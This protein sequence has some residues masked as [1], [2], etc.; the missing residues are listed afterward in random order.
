MVV[1]PVS[2]G[3]RLGTRLSGRE[4]GCILLCQYSV[5]FTECDVTLFKICGRSSGRADETTAESSP[6]NSYQH[7][8]PLPDSCLLRSVATVERRYQGTALEQY[9]CRQV[10]QPSYDSA[11]GANRQIG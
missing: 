2:M 1:E 7:D 4:F 5:P 10:E 9:V 11:H 8:A 3:Q 6:G